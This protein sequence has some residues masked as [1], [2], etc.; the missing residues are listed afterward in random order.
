MRN[1]LLVTLF[2][3][4]A[5]ACA[6]RAPGTTMPREYTCSESSVVP[7]GRTLEVR[8]ATASAT[9]MASASAKL[10]WHDG[11]GD[12]YV[13]GPMSPIDV[14]AVEFIVPGDASSDATK[15]T[16]DTSAGTARTDWRLLKAETCT[17]HGGDSDVLAHYAK[18][19]SLDD[20]ARDYSLADRDEARQVVHRAMLS[21]QKR[22]FRD[23]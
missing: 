8:E 6:A 5:V 22:Y 10:G 15:R 11:S 14:R 21:L 9:D 3:I 16:Y 23:R 2:S 1:I 17:V 12:H 7:H 19:E 4:S 13:S 20:I 18:G